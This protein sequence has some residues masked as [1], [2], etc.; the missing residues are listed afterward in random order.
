MHLSD[1]VG[2]G[3]M[4]FL[5]TGNKGVPQRHASA[6]RQLLPVALNL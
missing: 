6:L 1:N 3:G 4:E 5:Q 2:F